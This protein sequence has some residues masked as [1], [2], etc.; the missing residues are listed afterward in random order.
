[1]LPTSS[2]YQVPGM[3][4][5]SF[6]FVFCALLPTGEPVPLH[7]C[8]YPI[9]SYICSTHTAVWYQVVRVCNPS[10]VWRNCRTYRDQAPRTQNGF[11]RGWRLM[12]RMNRGL[13]RRQNGRYR[14]RAGGVRGPNLDAFTK[15][16]IHQHTQHMSEEKQLT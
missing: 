12:E 13:H 9:F 6:L 11:G 16:P 15:T 8:T 3:K 7:N 10:G 5:I 14:S 2:W 1:M 4:T